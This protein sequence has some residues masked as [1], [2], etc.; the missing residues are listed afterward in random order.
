MSTIRQRKRFTNQLLLTALIAAS[1]LAAAPAATAVAQGSGLAIYDQQLRI[2][3][4]EQDPFTRQTGFDYGGWFTFALFN[5]DDAIVPQHRTDRQYQLRAWA[6]LNINNVHKFYVRG[7][8]GYD[9][10]NKGDNPS[11]HID[12]LI[13][14]HLE[15]GWYKFDLGQMLRNQ[16]GQE[17]PVQF[18]VTVGRQFATIGT[19]L[20]LSLPL[21]M[22]LLHAAYGPWDVRVLLGQTIESTPN[23]DYSK[24]VA[25]HMDRCIWGVEL[26]YTGF[27]RHRPFVYFLSNQDKTDENPEDAL[28]AYD[29]SSR[30]VGIGSKGS[31]LLTNL[32][33]SVEVV[34]EWG[35]TY[36]EGVLAGQ[37]E[38]CAMAADAQL[39]YS[40]T[41][42]TSPKIYTGY[43]WA[44]GD[45]DRRLSTN[46]TIG[47]NLAGTKDNAFN[48]FGY[49]DTG[50]AFAPLVSNLH[51]Y[52]IGGSLLPLEDH[53]LFE[54]FEF[55]S[56]VF[57]YQ[58]SNSSG[59]ISDV[60]AS[61][62]SSWVGWEWDLYCNW[63][64]T[65][66]LSWSLRYG[67]FMPGEAFD[68]ETCRQFLYTGLTLSF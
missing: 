36:S 11:V 35:D 15:R 16:S 31:L 2:E 55:G 8:P 22:V 62:S 1:F 59:A 57:F 25:G 14:P 7:M 61:H 24:P 43:T 53:P 34:G 30:Y 3:L 26:A 44:S 37:D 32:S 41:C 38:I 49:R 48:A 10:W 51:I 47:G 17:A 50:V 45:D 29:Y 28:Q 52:K 46:S 60:T 19:E 33:Y 66:D 68:D 20:T 56:T 42:P 63:R 54:R 65:S 4:D 9:D 6:S 64:I 21:D 40:F 18:D 12:D 58:K 5:Y 13:E 23:I 67:A 39:E 27:Q